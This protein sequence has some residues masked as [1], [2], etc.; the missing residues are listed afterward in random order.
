MATTGCWRF[1]NSSSSPATC[2]TAFSLPTSNLYMN[3][4]VATT[5]TIEPSAAAAPIETGSGIG[6]SAWMRDAPSSTLRRN[7]SA[8][9][10]PPSVPPAQK[11]PCGVSQETPS[12]TG[13]GSS[14]TFFQVPSGAR[15]MTSCLYTLTLRPEPSRI[16]TKSLP[17]ATANEPSARNPANGRATLAGAVSAGF[18]STA[19]GVAHTAKPATA[20]IPRKNALS[21]LDFF[22]IF[23]YMPSNSC[24]GREPITIRD[25]ASGFPAR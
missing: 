21:K 3:P 11:S 10:V 25:A 13:C 17:P 9:V 14:P 12:A 19:T 1:L 16:P 2:Q 5:Y 8:K 23:P 22:M 20:A 24:S 6:G 15:T 7:A 4:L 18:H